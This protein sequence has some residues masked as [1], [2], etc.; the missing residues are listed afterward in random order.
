MRYLS[1]DDPDAVLLIEDLPHH[2][3]Q[4]KATLAQNKFACVH[5]T[6]ADDE[7][8]YDYIARAC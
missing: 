5:L 4:I 8:I 6:A 3:A 7:Q 2:A 1:V